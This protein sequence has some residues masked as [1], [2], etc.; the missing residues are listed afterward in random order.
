[1]VC[2]TGKTPH[3]EKDRTDTHTRTLQVFTYVET[4]SGE[5]GGWGCWLGAVIGTMYVRR[6]Y[7]RVIQIG[8]VVGAWEDILNNIMSMTGSTSILRVRRISSSTVSSM[9]W[10]YSDYSCD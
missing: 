10:P 1:M 7:P 2:S 6:M 5:C 9:Y 8:G 4:G 3:K